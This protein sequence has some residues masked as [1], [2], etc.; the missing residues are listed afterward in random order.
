MSLFGR[1]S[2]DFKSLTRQKKIEV[3]SDPDELIFP[4][5]QHSGQPASV[6]V[7]KGD[8]VCVGQKIA[9]AADGISANVHASVS[10]TVVGIE[11]YVHYTGISVLSIIIQNDF[12]YLVSPTIRSVLPLETLSPEDV[13][14]CIGEAGIVEMNNRPFPTHIKLTPLKNIPINTL[15]INGTECEPY[16]TSEYCVM[17]EESAD[18]MLGVKAAMKACGATQ[19]IIAINSH[20]IGAIKILNTHISKTAGIVIK[21]LPTGYPQDNEKIITEIIM[22]QKIREFPIEIGVI[23]LTLATVAQIGKTIGTGMPLIDRVVTLFGTALPLLG[24]YRIRMGVPIRHLLQTGSSDANVEGARQRLIH[25]GPLTGVTLSSRNVVITKAT[26]AIVVM[27]DVLNDESA[28]IRCARCIRVCPVQLIPLA[29]ANGTANAG[30]CI[31]C[32]L[33]AY[34]C[35]AKR[36]LV[37]RIRLN[38]IENKQLTGV[39]SA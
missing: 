13:C 15:I 33:C 31:E 35:P 8:Q 39:Q 29:L 4:V 6:I 7:K 20:Q 3:F 37:Q 14:Q 11:D 36:Y 9:A 25:G 10:G 22:K 27:N 32:G 23:V 24:N 5:I 17:M 21:L 16:L 2:N 38:K 26:T 28:C 18:I 30:L 12:Q 19:A 1:F 34:V